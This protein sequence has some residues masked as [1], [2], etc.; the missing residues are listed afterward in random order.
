[1]ESMTLEQTANSRNSRNE[2]EFVI[3][4]VLGRLG[5]PRGLCRVN[6]QK[7]GK[8]QFR[9][10]IYCTVNSDRPIN[11]VSMTDSFFVTVTDDDIVSKPAIDRKYF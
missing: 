8:N 6:A 9:V 1:M 5:R 4:K 10:N 2:E 7:V 3:E 11:T